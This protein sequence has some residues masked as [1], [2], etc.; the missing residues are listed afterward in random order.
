MNLIIVDFQNDFVNG[1]LAVPG[2][3]TARDNIITFIGNNFPNIH[4][5][6]FTVDNH[7]ENHCSFIE[8]GGKWPRHCVSFTKGVAIDEKLYDFCR[9]QFIPCIKPKG[10]NPNKEEYASNILVDDPVVC[11]LAGDYCVKETIIHMIENGY[12]PKVFYDGIASIDGG[13]TLDNYIK[14]YDLVC[15]NINN[16]DYKL[17]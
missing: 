6:F 2:A 14:T 9:Q 17:C 8:N 5:I 3:E 11:G 12:N 4:N 13:I 7:P 1:S 10:E 16:R 15:V